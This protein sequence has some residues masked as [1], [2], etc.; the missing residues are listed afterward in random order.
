V[1]GLI[2]LVIAAEVSAP[3]ASHPM[4]LGWW[5]PPVVL[6]LAG[7]IGVGYCAVDGY[8]VG[9][10]GWLAPACL[11]LPP[12]QRTDWLLLVAGVLHAEPDP[13]RRRH[14]VRGFLVS[15]PV[16]VA[17]GWKGWLHALMRPA[18]GSGS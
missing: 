17:I 10:P 7:V 9:A 2:V 6:A 3:S 13:A 8:R 1:L 11:M 5:N 12:E 14:E 18:S 4:I 15:M 16:T